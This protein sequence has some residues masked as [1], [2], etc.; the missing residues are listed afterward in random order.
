MWTGPVNKVS[1]KEIS[2]PVGPRTDGGYCRRGNGRADAPSPR[3]K[4][5]PRPTLVNNNASG[6]SPDTFCLFDLPPTENR[7][8]ISRRRLWWSV[9]CLSSTDLVIALI[10]TLASLSSL[11]LINEYPSAPAPFLLLLL[12]LSYLLTSLILWDRQPRLTSSSVQFF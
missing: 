8:L 7:V 1:Y 4:S 12:F 3:N 9:C 5:A 11:P 2:A 6:S 10:R